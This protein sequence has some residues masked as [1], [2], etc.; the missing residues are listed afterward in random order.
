MGG[1][2][3]RSCRYCG[4]PIDEGREFVF[5]VE[6]QEFEER[7]A[8]MALVEASEHYYGEPLRTCKECRNS[9]EQ[10]RRD[11]EEREAR[12]RVSAARIWSALKAIGILL[13]LVL[14]AFAIAD[15]RR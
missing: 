15:L 1:E 10:N 14:V 13:L 7:V 5:L 9:I 3:E 4:E 11:I 8:P 2:R 6:V 12:E